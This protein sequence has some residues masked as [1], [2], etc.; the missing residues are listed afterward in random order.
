MTTSAHRPHEFHDHPYHGSHERQRRH[1]QTPLR[2]SGHGNDSRP[3]GR[4][5]R[6]EHSNIAA[7]NPFLTHRTVDWDLRNRFL[8]ARGTYADGSRRVEIPFHHPSGI[9]DRIR[10]VSISIV[11]DEFDW[12]H[13]QWGNVIVEN[14]FGHIALEDIFFAISMYFGEIV[15][16]SE[17]ERLADTSEFQRRVG[18]A[19]RARNTE[20]LSKRQYDDRGTSVYRRIDFLHPECLKFHNLKIK[21]MG[22]DQC[23]LALALRRF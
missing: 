2:S 13:K 10:F 16:D 19:W 17:Y 9:P 23:H 15:E 18:M 6:T 4:H 21:S 1:R 7:L 11:N 3:S 20:D 5:S 12:L 14:R 22:R 8:T